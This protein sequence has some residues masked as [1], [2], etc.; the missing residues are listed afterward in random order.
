MKNKLYEDKSERSNSII[1]EE[2]KVVDLFSIIQHTKIKTFFVVNNEDKLLGVVTEGDLRRYFV[3]KMNFPEM[4]GPV[5]NR[6]PI[7]YQQE[8]LEKL[9]FLKLVWENSK[10]PVV[11]KDNTLKGFFPKTNSELFLKSK[12]RISIVAPTRITFAGGGSD[13]GYWFDEREGCVLNLAI[14]KYARVNISRNYSNEINITSLNTNE[15]LNINVMEVNDYRAST[16]Q[17]VVNCLKICKIKDGIDIQIFCDF[18]PGTGLGGSSSLVIALVKGLTSLFG[19]EISLRQLIKMAYFIEREESEIAGGWQDQIIAA[20]GG[21]CFTEFNNGDFSTK[22]IKLEQSQF[23]NLN[24]CLFL[25]KIGNSRSSNTIHREQEKNKSDE[26]YIENISNI[27]ELA[28]AC[29][30]DLSNGNFE[31]LGSTLHEGWMLKKRLGNFISNEKIDQRYKKLIE[32][33]ASGGRLLGA[34][35]AGYLLVLVPI[36]N[37]QNFLKHCMADNISIDRLAIEPNGVREI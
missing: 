23:D 29:A 24:S 15:K 18:E 21:L 34:G 12:E 31:A 20:H 8:E 7:T 19:F 32:F 35:G 22:K 2:T 3:E 33:G 4:I 16:L 6:Y 37:Q 14:A 13:V 36:V 17:L 9:K 1:L 27:V 11:D 10:I 26:K 28:K 30:Q 5:I 25:S